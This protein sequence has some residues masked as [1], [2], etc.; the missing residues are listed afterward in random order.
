MTMTWITR[1]PFLIALALLIGV[2]PG[3][4]PVAAQ[5][6]SR[7][8]RNKGIV[9]A[10]L[11]AINA[12]DFDVI[13]T[14]YAEGFVSS[15]GDTAAQIKARLMAQA[16]AFTDYTIT[17]N[18]A[19][20]QE[21]WV[22]WHVTY[23]GLFETAGE[24][25]PGMGVI[26]PTGEPVRFT[27]MV[28]SR[29]NEEGQVI[30]EWLQFSFL[31]FAAQLGILPPMAMMV[32]TGTTS[33]TEAITEPVG[34]E[35]LNADELA[36][37]FTSGMEARN[38]DIF[39]VSREILPEYYADPYI[40]RAVGT[41]ENA[42]QNGP[43]IEDLLGAAMPDTTFD[44]NVLVAEGDWVAALLTVRGTFTGEAQLGP[45][46]LTPTGEVIEWQIGIIARFNAD[47]QIV[48]EWNELDTTI[49]LTGLGVLPP[50]D[51]PEQ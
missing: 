7:E 44:T 45:L 11:E 31:N 40:L 21:D 36:A 37:T 19:I 1:T 10:G 12:G 6:E 43:N 5:E 24:V 25:I 33:G 22:V 3:V 26:E 42:S 28:F 48:E 17:L 49:V 47:G 50:M 27:M 39:N 4:A 9:I 51:G 38:L 20:A 35:L 13:D 34:Y 46:P 15:T 30:E 18:L 23:S 14:I 16:A 29:F 2:A 41:T 32:A 8:Q